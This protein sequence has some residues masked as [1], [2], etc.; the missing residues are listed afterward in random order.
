MQAETSSS[1]AASA[2]TIRPLPFGKGRVGQDRRAA[3]GVPAEL[4][5]PIAPSQAYW[6]SFGPEPTKG[7]FSAMMPSRR[8]TSV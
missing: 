6:T 5:H 3:D 4:G 7:S 8:A 2:A 1:V